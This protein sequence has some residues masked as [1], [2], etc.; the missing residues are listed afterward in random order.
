MEAE[1]HLGPE[2]N[3]TVQM[4]DAKS[5]GTEMGEMTWFALSEETMPA[6]SLKV[7]RLGV[8]LLEWP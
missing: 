7:S 5:H 1:G 8:H 3:A 4:G 2:E 6:G